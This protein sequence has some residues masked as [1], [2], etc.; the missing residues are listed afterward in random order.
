MNPLTTATERV[1]AGHVPASEQGAF[2][3][4][5]FEMPPGVGRLEVRYDYSDPIDSDP[6]IT[7]GNTVDLGLFDQRGIRFIEAGFRG[8]TG[9]ARREFYVTP[10]EATPGYLPGPL[11]PG[12]WHIFLG[13]Y[14]L[15][16]QGCHY[17]VTLR[18]FPADGAAA[19]L[20]VMLPVR[21]DAP[22]FPPKPD[23][24]YRGELHCHTYHSDGDSAPLELVRAAQ[25]LGL[26]FLAITD[27]NTLS[28]L[29]DLAAIDTPNL[30][31][32]PG[33]EITTYK[34]HWNVWGDS[35]WIDF[36]TLTPER[37]ESAIQ[38]ARE[39]GYLTS[40][41]HPRPYGPPWEFEDVTGSHCLEVWN[42]PWAIFNA[43]SLAYYE[44]RLNA[45]QQVVAVGGSDAHRLRADQ[46]V[47]A[48]IGTPTTWVYCP[49]PPS[50]AALL[51]AI[52]AGHV[53]ISEAPRGPQLYLT[54]GPAMMGD[55][56]ARPADN[57]LAVAVRVVD[58]AGQIVEVCGAPG[59]MA[60]LAV[61]SPDQV[62]QTELDVSGTPYVRAQL[63]GGDKASEM[64]ALTNPIYLT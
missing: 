55:S 15:S 60:R 32:I 62:F 33:V 37:M 39:R 56:V 34:G 47:I 24:W 28:H 54:A 9:S 19:P 7:G 36:R 6:H 63:V 18:F 31:L 58:G 10:G 4:L 41:N 17:Q 29:I 14:K 20:P 42:G 12:K 46:T 1:I 59:S 11:E 8:W 2:L 50:A 3:H 51:D 21:R 48:H 49:G 40:C 53:F 16:P 57:R 22:A 30:I 35:G 13:L 43:V 44:K 26:D 27:H 5:P 38:V 25:A 64:H 45:G 61:E 23:G 52:R